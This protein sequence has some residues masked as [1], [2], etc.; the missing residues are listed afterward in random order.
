MI[1][2]RDTLFL[3]YSVGV[4]ITKCLSNGLEVRQITNLP[5]SSYHLHINNLTSKMSKK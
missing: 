3:V 4:I 2:L 1:N 5:V